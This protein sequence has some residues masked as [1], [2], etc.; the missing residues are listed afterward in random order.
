MMITKNDCLLLLS[1]L[2][3]EGIDTKDVVSTLYT[4]TGIDQSVLMFINGHRRFEVLN[5]YDRLRV[6]YNNK[7]SKLYKSIVQMDE[8]EPKDCLV[9]LSSLLTQILL[10]SNTVKD[11][12]QFLKHCRADEISK[13][14]VRYFQTY[15]LTLCLTL[16]RYIRAD[17]KAL[18]SLK[19]PQ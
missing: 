13:A 3:E 10:Y 2:E 12:E 8:K 14:L 5:F 6:N 15:D 11:K 9:T 1:E 4:S 19:I 17:L 16:L 7:K 18:E